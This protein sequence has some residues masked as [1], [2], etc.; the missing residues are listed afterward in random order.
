MKNSKQ[1]KQKGFTLIELMIVVAVI[2][3]LAA[4]A[5]PQ[6]QNYVKKSEAAA[7]LATLRSLTTNIDTFIADTGSFPT[8]ADAS[9]LGAATDMN[10]LGTIAFADSGASGA[11]ATF[12]FD[13]A[14][15]ALANTDTVELSKDPTTGLWTCTHSTGVT[16]KGC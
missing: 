3:V 14:A 6:Y 8:D 9:A 2:G 1:K 12:T 13:G 16:L 10:K 7:G 5:I 4:I 11:T 15:S